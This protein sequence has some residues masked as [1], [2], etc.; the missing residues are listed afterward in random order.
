MVPRGVRARRD[1]FAAPSPPQ[2]RPRIKGIQEDPN[3]DDESHD[4]TDNDAVMMTI[5]DH[6]D[7]DG[8]CLV[9]RIKSDQFL[10]RMM[11]KMVNS[12]VQEGLD[13][14]LMM[15]MMRMREDVDDVIGNNDDDDKDWKS[16]WMERIRSGD[17]SHNDPAPPEGLCL[18]SVDIKDPDDD[19]TR[20]TQKQKQQQTDKDKDTERGGDKHITINTRENVPPP[21][22]QKEKITM[23]S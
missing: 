9:F 4:R 7:E 16:R 18:W 6:D 11:R 15:M 2:R 10:R 14:V 1:V 22:F 13:V 12:L 8:C 3:R 19:N 23:Q 17:R 21:R 20:R 5:D